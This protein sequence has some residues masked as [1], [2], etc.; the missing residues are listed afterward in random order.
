MG[1]MDSSILIPDPKHSLKHENHHLVKTFIYYPLDLK[2]EK[3]K[4]PLCYRQIMNNLAI[5]Y[6]T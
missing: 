2:K 5:L 4:I 3:R 6:C 1:A